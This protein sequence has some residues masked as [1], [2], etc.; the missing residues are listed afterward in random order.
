MLVSMKPNTYPVKVVSQKLSRTRRVR[1][2]NR[3]ADRNRTLLY[4][5]CPIVYHQHTHIAEVVPASVIANLNRWANRNRTLLLRKCP[6]VP[7][8]QPAHITELVLVPSI[9]DEEEDDPD[10]L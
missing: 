5:K 6:I 8:H 4:R 7:H 3:W 10:R 9:S 1:N 2:L